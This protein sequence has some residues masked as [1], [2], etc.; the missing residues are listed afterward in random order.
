VPARFLDTNVI[1]R[2]L[3]GDDER[4]ASLAAQLLARVEHGEER[5]A[6]SPLVAFEV[7]FLLHH[8][9]G[10]PRERTRELV[11]A[12]ISLRGIDLPD[13]GLW[14]RALDFFAGSRLSFA[15]AFNATYM[16]EQGLAEIYSWDTDFDRVNGITRVEPA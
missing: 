9:Y 11:R 1:V 2:L 10:L 16:T 7:I 5:V 6:L 14:L 8:T 12:L 3:T 15:D 4:K 13:K